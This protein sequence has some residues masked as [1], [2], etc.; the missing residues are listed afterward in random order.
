MRCMTRRPSDGRTLRRAL[1][2]TLDFQL[3]P[4]Y[5]HVAPIH[6]PHCGVRRLVQPAKILCPSN[7]PS[8]PIGTPPKSALEDWARSSLVSS[9]SPSDQARLKRTGFQGPKVAAPN[10]CHSP[11]VIVIRPLEISI[12]LSLVC[13]VACCLG[14]SLS[15]VRRYST[16]G[17]QLSTSSQRSH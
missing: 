6:S 2:T 10:S 3:A 1:E 12:L 17:L 15:A 13:R 14:D 8:K 9:G 16:G 7:P 4:S 11:W 5:L